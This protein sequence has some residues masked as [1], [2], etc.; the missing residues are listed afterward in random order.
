MADLAEVSTGDIIT[1]AR[2]NLVKDYVEDGTHKVNTLS[3]DIG[4]NET[5]DSNR[6]V[7]P[8]RI[9]N[10]DSTGTLIYDSAGTTMVA[11]IDDNG[12]LYIKGRV[13]TI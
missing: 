2:A 13:I 8:V 11:K 10:P 1:S 4:G 7:T 12:N 5:I 9:I 6:Y 3:L